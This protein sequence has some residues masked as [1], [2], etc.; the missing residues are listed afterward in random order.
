[1][2]AAIRR[3]DTDIRFN[4]NSD[5]TVDHYDRVFLIRDILHTQEGDAKLDGM[6]GSN[7]FEILANNFGAVDAAYAEGELDSD[8]IVGFSDLVILSNNFGAT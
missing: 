7:Y 5:G 1:M 6:F 2:A 4:V 3:G 8:G